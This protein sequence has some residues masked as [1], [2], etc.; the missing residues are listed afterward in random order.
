MERFK[1]FLLTFTPHDL[2]GQA[3]LTT[4]VPLDPKRPLYLQRM[5]DMAVSG[6]TTLDID[7]QHLKQAQPEL[8]T[9]LITFPK[10]VIPACD[11]SL[12]ALFIDRFR[13]ARPERPLQV[14]LYVYQ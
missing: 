14:R 10:E 8:Y 5:E 3:G 12:H 1:R 9:Q 4:G 2:Q 13:E 7:C 11:A 6:N